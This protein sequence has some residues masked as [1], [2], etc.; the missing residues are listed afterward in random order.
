MFEALASITGMR[1][2]VHDIGNALPVML[3]T[4]QLYPALIFFGRLI[5]DIYSGRE[6]YEPPGKDVKLLSC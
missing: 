5:H 2:A 6:A 3:Y 4:G 1:D